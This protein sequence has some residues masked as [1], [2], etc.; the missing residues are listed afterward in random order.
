MGAR[1]INPQREPVRLFGGG[2]PAPVTAPAEPSALDASLRMLS[3]L[4]SA[5]EVEQQATP[6]AQDDDS[7]VIEP[8]MLQ[9]LPDGRFAYKQRFILSSVGMEAPDDV[10][11]DEW[12]DAASFLFNLD[13]ALAWW[14]GDLLLCAE[15][16][17]K[18][19][20]DAVAS[21][22]GK[23]IDTLYH[24]VHTAKMVKVW[25][26]NPDVSF[27]HHRLIQKLP[28]DKQQYWLTQA[29]AH[30][31]TLTQF[32]AALANAKQ[33]PA[34]SLDH[35]KGFRRVLD[36]AYEKHI[37]AADWEQRQQMVEMLEQML[38]RLQSDT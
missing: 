3:K 16:H 13:S 11:K 32:R 37:V 26:R 12:E 10:N 8:P 9:R 14:L 36:S 34:K 24:Y 27:S 23:E 17:W 38:A 1:R 33:R 28:E 30:Q 29:A 19:T 5:R 21:A 15:R 20:Y 35:V 2:A 22:Y 31:W 4:A 25:I 7:A 6:A 18:Y